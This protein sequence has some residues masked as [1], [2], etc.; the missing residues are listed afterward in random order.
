MFFIFLYYSNMQFLFNLKVLY[1]AKLFF[2]FFLDPVFVISIL[3]NT[4]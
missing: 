4:F 2:F 1:V 3:F